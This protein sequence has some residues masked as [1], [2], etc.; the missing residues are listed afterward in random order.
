[1]IVIDASA[2]LEFLLQ[3]PLGIRVEARLFR[4]RDEFHS[5][6]L[7]D[8]EI[9]Q[10]LRRLVRAGEVSPDRAA[11]A[12]ADLADLDL[13]RHAHL[14]LLMRAWKLREDITA[15]DGMYV[16][17]AE[18]LDALIVT[19]DKPLSKASGHRARIELIV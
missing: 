5:P 14:D 9:T 4:E 17:L 11:E 7:V 8:V 12:I 16:A 2:L 10:G 18:A 15:Y 3:T 13:H 1:M 19:C 6:H